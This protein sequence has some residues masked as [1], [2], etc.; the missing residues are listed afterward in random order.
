MSKAR[1]VIT[2]V[3]LADRPVAQVARDDQVARSW[4]YELLARYHEHGEAYRTCDTHDAS[5]P[6]PS[7][8]PGT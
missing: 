1:L 7:P 4:I 2:A 5:A 8:R 3:V 6:T